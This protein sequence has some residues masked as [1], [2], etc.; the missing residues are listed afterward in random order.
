MPS[1]ARHL[2][3]LTLVSLAL[4]G[5]DSGPAETQAERPATPVSVTTLAARE[6]EKRVQALG[7]LLARESID[8]TTAVSEKITAL[9]FQDGQRV[10]QGQLLATLAQQEE[11]ALLAS[12][13]ADLAEQDRELDR[14]RGLLKRNMASQTE[15]DQR[16]TARQRAQARLEEVQ[17]MLDERNIRAPFD[18][19]TGLRRVSPG[20]LITPG[21]VITTLDDTTVMRMDFQMPALQLRAVAEGQT[22]EAYSD[23]LNERFRGTITAIDSRIDPIARNISVRAE[24]ANP[25]GKL[26][27]GMLMRLAL[28]TDQRDALMVPEE[29]LQSIQ[30][31]HYVWVVDSEQRAKRRQIEL[32]LRKP[33][34]VEARSGL[35]PGDKIISQGFTSLQDGVKVSPRE[36]S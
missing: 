6:V 16:D 36:A 31:R 8:V 22:V 1:R 19:V 34:Y 20:A 33:G 25:E 18:G 32:G 15:F 12:A 5:C 21:E 29:A 9:H 13:A 27:P 4:A 3:G 2:L 24:I 26:K 7:T 35:D 28:I 10:K 23:A 17:A 14:L 11:K 30:D